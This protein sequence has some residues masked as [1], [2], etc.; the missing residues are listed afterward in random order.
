MTANPSPPPAKANGQQMPATPLAAAPAP[1]AIAVAEAEVALD[2]IDFDSA[3]ALKHSDETTRRLADS[4]RDQGLLNPPLVFKDAATGRYQ[5]LAGEGR[6]LAMKLLGWAKTRVRI[7]PGKPDAQQARDL[8]LID[9]LV[10]TDLD[11]L[12]FGLYCRDDM[13]RTGRSAR[14]LAQVLQNKFSPTTITRAVALVGKLPE[15]VLAM[16][17]AKTLP[18]GV[19]RTLTGL[20]DDDAKRRFAR[21]Y[22]D[23]T[24][25]TRDELAAAVRAS[26]KN[27]GGPAPA[28]SFT[29]E[30]CGVKVT[31]T[32]P[33]TS[34]A[35]GEEVLRN[36]VKDV[37]EHGHRGIEHFR[38]YLAKKA[39]LL[40]AQSALAG[41]VNQPSERSPGNG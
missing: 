7:Y 29:W 12:G 23:R 27:G 5:L 24:L 25:K 9:N 31:V 8:A 28:G 18:P 6:C 14:E 11:P 26:K 21:L 36:L 40:A 16:I 19:A 34:L 41:H 2:Q 30:E 39:K 22:A 17:R 15:D 3:N 20:A 37:K 32:L 38:E 33:G 13:A 35:A 1:A 10:S 4:I